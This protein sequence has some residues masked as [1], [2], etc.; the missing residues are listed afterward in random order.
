MI[1]QNN[2]TLGLT[3]SFRNKNIADGYTWSRG[4]T[5]S[6]LDYIY[7]SNELNSRIV[8]SK[9]NWAFDKSDHA[10]VTTTLLKCEIVQKGPGIIKV[11][12]EILKDPI[13]K[14]QIKKE[15]LFLIDQMLINWNGHMKL[16]YLKMILRTTIAQSV[17]RAR[18]DN[19]EELDS[20]E[21]ALNEMEIIKQKVTITTGESKQN[22]NT[23]NR[24]NT[25]ENARIKIK[26]NI[27][28]VR[29]KID[30]E[31]S[32][33]T[34]AKWFEY[35]EKSNKFFLNLNK[36][37]SRQKLISKIRTGEKTFTGQKE[38]EKG[39]TEFYQTLYSKTMPKNE[40]ADTDKDFF[41]KCP[42]PT[43]EQ[44]TKMDEKISINEMHQ[45][46]LTCKDSAPGPDEIPYSVYKHYLDIVG[47]IL[48]EAWD[49]S[50]AQGK[51]PES[52]KESVI[53]ILPKE[54]KDITDIKN[55]RP[56]TLTNCDAKIVTKAF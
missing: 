17:G 51:L 24:L 42:K 29:K 35:V 43:V 52:H 54:G 8:K 5:Y 11:N 41:S 53:T 6:R 1:E 12:A 22:S 49:Y 28:K 20:L 9:V 38:I 33:K 21:I 45:A 7:I 19:R 37:K 44:K 56:I 4:N 23:T 3:D 25:I 10:A 34:R 47:P 50:I 16:E 48:K 32:F 55:W 27:E 2:I 36:F 31:T 13:K 26:S 40:T 46:L 14:A 39:I 15:L 30:E 18:K